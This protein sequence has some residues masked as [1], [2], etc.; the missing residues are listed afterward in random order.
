MTIG[1]RDVFSAIFDQNV[2]GSGESASGRGSTWEQTQN[3]RG[4]LPWVLNALGVTS[5]VGAP[6]GDF[7]RIQRLGSALDLYIGVGNVPALF[8]RMRTVHGGP[9][10][11]GLASIEHAGAALGMGNADRD[12]SGRVAAALF[13]EIHRRLLDC[14]GGRKDVIGRA[15]Q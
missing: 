7:N 9:R 11:R 8:D 12:E 4:A 5:L 2:L 13:R 3:L 10:R 14:D 15:A 6:R 1:D